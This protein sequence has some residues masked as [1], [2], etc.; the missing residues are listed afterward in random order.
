MTSDSSTPPE[1]TAASHER[2]RQRQLRGVLSSMRMWLLACLLVVTLGGCGQESEAA[3][4]KH[5]A[6]LERQGQ[7]AYTSGRDPEF[8]ELA[9]KFH[10]DCIVNGIGY[11][12]VP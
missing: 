6:A 3:L 2:P 9:A 5:C 1:Q 11:A 7:R 4:K 12:D 10:D 8:G